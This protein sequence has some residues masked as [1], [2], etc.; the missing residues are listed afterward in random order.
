MNPILAHA[1]ATSP[2]RL[3]IAAGVTLGFSVLA[4]ATRGVNRS[5]AVA[6]G[7]VCILLYACAGP[8]AFATLVTL[9]VLTWSATHL[10]YARKQELGLAERSEGRSAQQVLANLGTPAFSAL[11]FAVTGQAI[12]LLAAS[13]ALAEAAA[14]T[15]ASETG[16]TGS[17]TAFLITTGEAVPAGTNGGITV[18][19]TLAG[20]AA[21]FLLASIAVMVRLI[22]PTQLWIPAAAG[23]AGMLVD[24]V[25]GAVCERRGWINN[26]GVNFLGTLSAALIAWG[27]A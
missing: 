4:R 24:S 2:G 14:D 19:G 11:I 26:D 17:R 27:C 18:R 1:W 16:E 15:V 13:A 3:A 6:G 23:F 21:A 20:A 25:L 8:G 7:V 12:W 10:G 9:F 22:A 5:G